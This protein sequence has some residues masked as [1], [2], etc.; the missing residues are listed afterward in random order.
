MSN[1]GFIVGKFCPLHLGHCFLID[2]A[3]K[4]CDNL[5]ILSYSSESI[6]YGFPPNMREKYLKNLYPNVKIIVLEDNVVPNDLAQDIVHRNFCAKICEKEN[7][8][9]DIIFTSEYYGIGFTDYMQNY[10]HK[11]INHYMVDKKRINYNI[12]ATK[13]RNNYHDKNLWLKF[14]NPIVLKE[15]L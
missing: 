15:I 3:L 13:L 4:H 9:P 11:K 7:F 5:F 1:K 8:I 2:T 10:F 14:V 12:S 6:K